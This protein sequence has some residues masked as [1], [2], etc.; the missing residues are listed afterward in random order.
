VKQSNAVQLLF[1]LALGSAAF[2]FLKWRDN[3]IEAASARLMPFMMDSVAVARRTDSLPKPF[4]RL[5]APVVIVPT[6]QATADAKRPLRLRAEPGEPVPVSI[7]AYCLRGTT[8]TGTQVRDG[9]VAADPRVFPLNSEIE[10]RIR[11]ES[12]GLFR[13]EDTGLLIKGRKIDLWL[14]NCTDARTFGRKRGI[15]TISPKIRR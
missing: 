9:I 1:S 3:D 15:A 11:D 13:V 12:L 5:K 7:T 2:V 4:A 8:R 6:P 14:E 10:L